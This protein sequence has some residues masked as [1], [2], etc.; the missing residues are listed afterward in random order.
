MQRVDRPTDSPVTARRRTQLR[1]L[2]RFVG[3]NFAILAVSG[4]FG[5]IGIWRE[6][7]IWFLLGSFPPLV[8]GSLVSLQVDR[9]LR[10]HMRRDLAA[11]RRSANPSLTPVTPPLYLGRWT[12]SPE[13]KRMRS[14]HTRRVLPLLVSLATLPISFT[15][16]GTHVGGRYPVLAFI[17][18]LLLVAFFLIQEL[19]V[20]GA[21]NSALRDSLCR[22]YDA[23]RNA[24]LADVARTAA[25]VLYLRSF[26]DDERA[27][28]RHK[29]LTEEEHLARALAWMGPLVAVG[30]P[31]ER[32]P[33][34]TTAHPSAKSIRGAHRSISSNT[35]GSRSGP[36]A[37]T[38]I[39]P[40]RRR[41]A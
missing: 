32:L 4:A 33:K 21:K 19:R 3:F 41:S 11:Q 30:R 18:A 7:V 35:D 29:F 31:G 9:S 1:W 10:L 27:G 12:Y 28:K 17:V 20:G 26:T 15:M 16:V 25:P 6:Y 2:N 34:V 36:N 24:A 14:Q 23:Q 8:I 40:T 37:T 22:D 38:S 39:R 13:T 5:A